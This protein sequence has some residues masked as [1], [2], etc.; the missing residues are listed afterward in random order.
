VVL[1]RV[2]ENQRWD[3]DRGIKVSGAELLADGWIISAKMTGL[4]LCPDRGVGL[5]GRYGR[6]V[7]RLQDLPVQGRLGFT[8]GA[9]FALNIM[10]NA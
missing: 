9:Q 2:G 7:W 10:Q 4:S 6:Y 5:A 3:L 1:L 8:K